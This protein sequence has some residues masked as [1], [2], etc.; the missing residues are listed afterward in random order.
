[1]G[2]EQ[3]EQKE[4]RGTA[5]GSY[6]E[7]RAALLT[8]LR[9][10]EGQVRGIQRMVESDTYCVDIITQLSAVIA[11]CEKVGLKVLED[12][13]RGCVAD[14]IGSEDGEAKIAELTSVLER[15][16]QAGRSAVSASRS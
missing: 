12:H 13:I 9:R 11:A 15:F 1:M 7:H 10:I 4:K 16:L 5:G 14:A 6:G 2:E 3:V 8:R